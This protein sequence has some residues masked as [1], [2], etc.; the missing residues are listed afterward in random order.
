[1]PKVGF[2]ALYL[3]EFLEFEGVATYKYTR[4]SN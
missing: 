2:V 1:M 4:Y 3:V